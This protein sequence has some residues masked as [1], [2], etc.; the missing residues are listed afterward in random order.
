LIVL[1]RL[2]LLK[3]EFKPSFIRQKAS[4]MERN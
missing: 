3:S 4:E 1:L 2:E